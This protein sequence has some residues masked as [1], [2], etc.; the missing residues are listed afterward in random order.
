MTKVHTN[1][2]IDKELRDMAKARNISMSKTLNEALAA[3]LSLPN[4]EEE[5]IVKE[6][7]LKTEL[8][9]VR[10]KRDQMKKEDVLRTRKQVIGEMEEDVKKL[11]E[12]WKAKLKGNV[13][14]DVFAEAI[15]H[16]CKTW[17]VDR[18]VAIDYAEGRKEV[19]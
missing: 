16:F 17:E 4:T 8:E 18:R 1:V 9:A 7:N 3:R 2:L 13:K 15:G 11:R 10:I 12:L 6:H 14:E 19:I 5:L